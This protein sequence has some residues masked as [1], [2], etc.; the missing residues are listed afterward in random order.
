MVMEDLRKFVKLVLEGH[1]RGDVQVT[2]GETVP[3]GSLAHVKDLEGRIA[4]L[5][6]WRN[7]STRGSEKRANYARLISQLRNEL[8]S[9]RRFAE[10]HGEPALS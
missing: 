7:A 8:R 1:S 10:K 6:V 3:F 9:A 5:L 2:N 4:Q